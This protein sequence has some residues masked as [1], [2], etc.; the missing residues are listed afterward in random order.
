M[1]IQHF[2]IKC[3]TD[4]IS[5]AFYCYSAATGEVHPIRASPFV[6]DI[7][8]DLSQSITLYGCLLAIDLE[9][10]NHAVEM[11]EGQVVVV[12]L[13]EGTF[14]MVSNCIHIYC[15]ILLDFYP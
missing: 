7:G 6:L 8:P 3:L 11:G 1:C 15:P 9:N 13:K 10:D 4:N 5:C 14:Q 12:N 2:L